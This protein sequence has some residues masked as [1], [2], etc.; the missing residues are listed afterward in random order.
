MTDVLIFGCNGQLGSALQRAQRLGVRTTSVDID[1]LDVVERANTITYIRQLEPKWVVNCAAYT[2]V[3]KAEVEQ[4]VA[5]MVNRD[6][7]ENIGLG[8]R[9]VGA[10]LIHIST[11]Y[12]FD[13]K[14][15]RPYSP[16]DEPNP[17]NVYGASKL[18]GEQVLHELLPQHTMIIRTAWLYSVD[19]NNFVKTMLRLMSERESLSVVADQYGSPTYAEGLADAIW[20]IIEGNLF[21]SGILHWTDNGVISWYEFAR[22]IHEEAMNLD[23]LNRVISI[24]PISSDAY[25]SLTR[26]AAFSALNTDSIHDLI[27]IDGTSW[28]A[29]LKRMLSVYRI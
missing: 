7:V 19:G 16:D 4:D 12:V 20:R 23:L 29:N 8:C 14:K 11:D 28:R 13:G 3:D 17:L 2:D 21:R 1:E 26:R 5:F 25:R 24:D 22:A 15:G 10:R 9:Q 27:R 18:A 6:A